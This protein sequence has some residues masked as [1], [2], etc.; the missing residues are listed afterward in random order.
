MKMVIIFAVLS[1]AARCGEPLDPGVIEDCDDACA[2]VERLGCD[3]A[4]GS[5]GKDEEFGTGDDKSC[6]QVCHET[7][8]EGIPLRPGCVATAQSCGD[9]EDCTE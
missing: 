6:L 3:G 5:P 2:N 7:M 4:E 8:R 9:V 1:L